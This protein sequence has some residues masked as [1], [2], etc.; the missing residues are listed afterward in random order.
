MCTKGKTVKEKLRL[1][2]K[3]KKSSTYVWTKPLSN[4]PADA[5]ALHSRLLGFFST[6][7]VSLRVSLFSLPIVPSLSVSLPCSLLSFAHLLSLHSCPAAEQMLLP[8]SLL[9]N[10]DTDREIRRSGAITV[11]QTHGV[12]LKH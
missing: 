4:P 11:T 2:K 3:K 5:F 10:Q 1:F 6:F 9:M 8:H 7:F 12:I